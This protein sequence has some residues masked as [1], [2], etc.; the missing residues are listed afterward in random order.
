MVFCFLVAAFEWSFFIKKFT[1]FTEEPFSALIAVVFI[2]KAFL[3]M[4]VRERVMLLWVCEG[5]GACEEVD[6]VV[7]G[8]DWVVWV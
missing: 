4:G 3:K 7:C 5:E 8:S 6:W 2:L 1:R